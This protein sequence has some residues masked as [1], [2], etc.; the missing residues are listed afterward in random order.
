MQSAVA[1]PD[2][3][4]AGSLLEALGAAALAAGDGDPPDAEQALATRA[5][6]PSSAAS[7]TRRESIG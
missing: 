5:N 2:A 3:L 6:V 7:L 4:A 1:A